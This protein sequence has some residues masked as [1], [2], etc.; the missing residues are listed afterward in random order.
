[1]PSGNVDKRDVNERI[2]SFLS[3]LKAQVF[4][5]SHY[6]AHHVLDLLVQI[7]SEYEWNNAKEL[8]DVIRR[9]G[10]RMMSVQPSESVIGNMVRRV[11]K[12]I[13]E[14]YAS[15]EGKTLGDDPQ[16]A[17]QKRFVSEGVSDDYTLQ[18][19]D[20]QAIVIEAISEI[21]SELETCIPNIESQALEH[22][23][24]KEII[25][26]SGWSKSVE[27]FLKSAARKRKF[28]VMVTEGAPFFHGQKMAKSLAASN[29]ETTLITDS[30]VFAMMS[31]VNKV[32]IGTHTVLANGGLKAVQGSH[33]IALAAKYHSV[34]LIVVA[35]MFKLSP[36][37]LCSY[38]QDAFNRFVSPNDVVKF[39][40][41]AIVSKV[42]I[43]N[44]VFDYVPPEL[45]TL[46]ISNIGGNAPSYVYRLL[47]EL[48]HTEDNDLD[49]VF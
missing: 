43:C 35:A 37:Y 23:H 42:Q 22:I 38:D 31:R 24:A 47:S 1:M 14:E 21:K 2:E 29:I 12:V 33:S 48:Y 6:L 36:Q 30:A 19:P 28:Q 4:F 8:M 20:F 11:L 10:K 18:V 5:S 46:F 45:V 39:S 44:P 34:P 15:A 3:E 49:K 27:A 40:E 16:E 26:T 7:I 25:M 32:I 9:E 13:R 17:L 41:S